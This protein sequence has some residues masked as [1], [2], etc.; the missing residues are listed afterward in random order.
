M[1]VAIDNADNPQLTTIHLVGSLGRAPGITTST[2]HLDVKSTAE[3][4]RAININTRGA[5]ERYLRGPGRDRGYRIALQKREN[6]IDPSEAGNRSGRSTI[7]ILP[8]LRG[9]NSGTGKIIAGAALLALVSLASAGFLTAAAGNFVGAGVFSG[10]S[11]TS[12]GLVAVGFGTSLILG[13]ITQLLTPTPRSPT[14]APD[15]VNSS[16]FQGNASVV[17]Q[18]GCVPLVYGRALV[19]P[20]PISI[21]IA[22]NDVPITDAGTVGTVVTT[23]LPG[24]STQYEPGDPQNEP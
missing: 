15:A 1:S 17:V 11:L 10:G 5:L 6:V 4:L 8:A 18:G 21:T 9:R 24:G 22:N 23:N 2:W 20:I 13:G 16:T 3:A 12:A 19:S 14:D 7:Y